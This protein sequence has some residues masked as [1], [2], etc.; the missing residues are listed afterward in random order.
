MLLTPKK[1]SRG[2]VMPNKALQ[3]TSKSAV[4]LHYTL[5]LAASELGVIFQEFDI[6]RYLKGERYEKNHPL[7]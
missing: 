5:L 3:L 7:N 2:R 1:Q 6:K 4:P